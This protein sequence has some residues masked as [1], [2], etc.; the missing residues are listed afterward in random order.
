MNDKEKKPAGWEHFKG[1]ICFGAT[2]EDAYLPFY[3]VYYTMNTLIVITE[4]KK[5]GPSELITI[6]IHS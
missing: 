5:T 3:A 4:E 6:F 2:R 1:T